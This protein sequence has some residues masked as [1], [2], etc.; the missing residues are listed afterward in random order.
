MLF[1]VDTYEAELQRES[2]ITVLEDLEQKNQIL[3]AYLEQLNGSEEALSRE[4]NN[5]YY[6]QYQNRF[7][8]VKNNCASVGI[9]VKGLRNQ[10]KTNL[11]NFESAIQTSLAEED[12][13][14]QMLENVKTRTNTF[15]ETELYYYTTIETYLST[16]SMT[17]SQYDSEIKKLEE[18]TWGN[19][20]YSQQI[21]TLQQEKVTALSNL[22][23]EM[24]AGIEQSLLTVQTN[25]KDMSISKNQAQAELNN[26]NNGQENLSKEQIIENE[27]ASI[28]GELNTCL[29]QKEE[30]EKAIQSLDYSIEQGTVT[31]QCDGYLN[32]YAENV[33]GDYILSGTE[34]GSIIPTGDGTYKVQI[35][36]D[37]QDAGK[38]EEGTS[39]KYEIGAYPS[40]EYGQAKGIVTSISEDLKISQDTGKGYYLVE[41][42]IILPDKTKE[43]ELKQGMAV[44]AKVITGQ[45][46]VLKILLEKLDLLLDIS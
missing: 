43:M 2:A 9:E 44:E 22:E 18:A 3:N 25:R 21:A 4:E 24:V 36:L 45:R 46:S 12:K 6:T 20:D 14:N 29:A 26:L 7:V 40:S 23:N 1:R 31:A 13:L 5:P 11:E 8:L 37:N 42:T 39:V 38:I 10:Y 32:L 28:Y 41:A 17:A 35:Y 33:T 34:I 30:Y 16:Y 19:N 15:D 27:K